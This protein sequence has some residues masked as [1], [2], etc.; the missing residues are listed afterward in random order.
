MVTYWIAAACSNFFFSCGDFRLRMEHNGNV[1]FCYQVSRKKIQR[2]KKLMRPCSVGE[3][4]ILL[5]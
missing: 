5:G 4:F 1:G 2:A 3:V